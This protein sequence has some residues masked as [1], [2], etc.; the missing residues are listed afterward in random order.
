MPAALVTR[1]D[2]TETVPACAVF[3]A[4][5]ERFVR[6]VARKEL[7]VRERGHKA[8]ALGGGFINLHKIQLLIINFH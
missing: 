7:L 4:V 2:A 5:Q 8:A 3:A 1:R 6:R